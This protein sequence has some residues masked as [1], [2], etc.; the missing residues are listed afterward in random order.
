[1]KTVPPWMQ[2]SESKKVKRQSRKQEE[3]V[4]QDIGGRAHPNSGALYYAKGDVS[5]DRI[6][7]ECK[8]TKHASYSLS[9]VEL[10]RIEAQAKQVGKL[11]AFFIRFILTEREYVVLRKEDFL[12]WNNHV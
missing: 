10:T 1:M 12:C 2:Q 6:L 5:N 9:L 7:V 4:A 3:S 11:P 8:Q